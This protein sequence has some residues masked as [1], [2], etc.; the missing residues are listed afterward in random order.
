MHRFFVPP[1]AI[2]DGVVT[3]AGQTAHQITTVLR[4][5]VGTHIMVLDNS[6]WQ[7]ET[8]LT[9]VSHYRVVG[10]VVRRSLARGEPK[11]KV[12]LYQA[13]LKGNRLEFALQKGTEIGIV[14][15]VPMIT[16][17]C[18]IANLDDVNRKLDRW[19]RILQE[20]AEQS[21]RGRLPT[22]EPAMLIMQACERA[23]Q[24]GSLVLL[25]WEEERETSLKDVL[26]AGKM[27]FAITLLV[28]PEGGFTADEV[29]IARSY[30]ART[31]SLGTRVL[32]AETAG[33]VA[34]AAIFYESGDLEPLPG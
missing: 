25:P 29:R 4:M 23:R 34:A 9:E 22:I 5:S 30:G 33:L 12:S 21:R 14:E 10:H 8:E 19:E 18:V 16:A 15:F 32:R 24:T 17:H 11:I 27:P 28:G 2:S 1:Q 26:T 3:L 31:V 6:G 20:A 7:M 13:M